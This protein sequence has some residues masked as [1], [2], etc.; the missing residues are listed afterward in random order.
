MLKQ[1]LPNVPLNTRGVCARKASKVYAYIM[2]MP[3]L[4]GIIQLI[5]KFEGEINSIAV[6]LPYRWNKLHCVYLLV[7]V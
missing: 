2:Y 3:L 5:S 1:L 6:I 7:S 4:L